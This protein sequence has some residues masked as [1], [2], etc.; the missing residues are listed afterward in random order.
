MMHNEA[1]FQNFYESKLVQKLSELEKDRKKIIKCFYIVGLVTVAVAALA[2]LIIQH[3]VAAIAALILGLLVVYFLTNQPY[4]EF[5]H[6]FKSNVIADIVSFVD[7]NLHYQPYQS[8][9]EKRY[10]ESQL[11]RQRVDRYKGD[12]YI[13][14]SVGKTSLEFSELHTQYK[15]ITTDSKGRT[16]THWHTIFKGLFFSADFNKNF[17]GQT[18]VLPDTAQN[19]LGKFGQA[20]QSWGASHGQL[21]KLEDPDFEKAFVCYSS[22]QTE[23][24]YI[25][26]PALMQRIL[27]LRN[28]AGREIHLSFVGSHVYVAISYHKELF[29]PSLFSNLLKFK[30]TQAF[31]DDMRLAIG[32]VEDLNLNT[33]I[34]T[35]L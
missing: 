3:V 20:L 17:H 25:L 5:K 21:V 31:F 15:T 14:G 1:D 30:E 18:F 9:S 7:P 33:R 6:K 23:A 4:R 11:F 34:W 2:L 13:N 32:V 28:K 24:R 29:E 10:M 22:D 35:K 26:S 8:I 27:A 16:Q 19:L 12:D